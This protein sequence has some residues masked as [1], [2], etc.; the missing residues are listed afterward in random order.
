M[1]TKPNS[2][3]VP[4]AKAM[5]ELTDL[6]IDADHDQRQVIAEAIRIVCTPPKLKWYQ[7]IWH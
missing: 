7:R 5:A 6:M 1:F 3:Y 4:D 2:V